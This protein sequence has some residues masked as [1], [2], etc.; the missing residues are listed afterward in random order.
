MKSYDQFC[1]IA[2]AAEIFCERWTAQAHRGFPSC[3]EV[4]R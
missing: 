1:P 2:K 3:I 4:F